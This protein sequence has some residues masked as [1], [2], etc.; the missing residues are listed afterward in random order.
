[1]GAKWGQEVQGQKG[2]SAGHRHENAAMIEV[3]RAWEALLDEER[4]AWNL[5]GESRRMYGVNY[6]KKVNLRR[7]L[8]GEELATVP[9]QSEP[10]DGRRVLKRLRLGNRGGRITMDLEF[11]RVPTG[12]FT[13]WGSR[14]CN[15]GAARPDKCPRLGWLPPPKNGVSKIADLYFMKHGEYLEQHGVRLEGKRI[16]IRIRQEVDG[17]SANLYEEVSAVVPE[18]EDRAKRQKR[19]IPTVTPP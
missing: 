9:P 16:F 13:V 6:F 11:G 8:R 7:L 4:L 2:R 17:G 19:P 10:Y 5:E 14:P 18:P 1:M 12:P 15:R 3:M